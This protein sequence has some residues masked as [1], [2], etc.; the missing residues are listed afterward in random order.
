[1]VTGRDSGQLFTASLSANRPFLLHAIPT[2]LL[3]HAQF[4]VIGCLRIMLFSISPQRW[5]AHQTAV[6]KKTTQNS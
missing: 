6:E 4:T 3:N 1:M 2:S 5:N